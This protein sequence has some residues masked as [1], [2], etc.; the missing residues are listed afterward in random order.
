[1]KQM[2]EEDKRM[3]KMRVII[4]TF[5]LILGLVAC[6]K[7]DTTEQPKDVEENIETVVE[8]DGEEIEKN[9]EVKEVIPENQN[10]LTGIP[11]LTEEAI[12]K[13]PVAVMVNNVQKAL[14]QY[15]IEAAD[16]IFEI[17][18]EG[19]Q[20]R[21]MALYGDYTQVPEICSV[22]SCRKYFPIFSQGFD[23]VY[24]HWGMC[25]TILPEVNAMGLTRYDGMANTGGLYGRDQG[26][27]NSGYPLEHTSMFDGTGLPEAMEKR[28]ERTD[29]LD[30]KKEA[31][32]LFNGL[33]EQI[34][35][36]GKEC[37]EVEIEFGGVTAN[38]IYDEESNTYLKEF[39]GNA[40]VD[41]KTKNQLSFTNV[42]VLETEIGIDPVNGVHKKFDW[43]GGGNSKGY[44]VSNGAVQE[45]KWSK[46]GEMDYLK[47]YTLNGEELS[48]NRGKSYIAINYLDKSIYK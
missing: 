30:S 36:E 10:L 3:K 45:I 14:P 22:R 23:A 16:V 34:K 26:R 31:A 9:A 11:T 28:G 25:D 37:K 41:G 20:T 24:V 8:N 1:M 17:L 38:F 40:Q 29:L 48:I 43:T 18:V 44:Y 27:L 15:G 12:G 46:E 4:L 32:F 2:Y 35:P 5:L 21:F 13:R 42:F 47:F 6:K 33:E 7:S 19:D 39:N